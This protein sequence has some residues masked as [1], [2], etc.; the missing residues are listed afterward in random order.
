MISCSCAKGMPVCAKPP[1]ACR[2]STNAPT[3]YRVSW[4]GGGLEGAVLH[5]RDPAGGLVGVG[6]GPVYAGGRQTWRLHASGGWT[7]S[8]VM[9]S[10]VLARRAFEALLGHDNTTRAP[11]WRGD[12]RARTLQPRKPPRLQHGHGHGLVQLET[13]L[14][15][16][17]RRRRRGM[18]RSLRRRHRGH[19]GRGGIKAPRPIVV[20]V[21]PALE[22]RRRRCRDEAI[23][24]GRGREGK[25]LR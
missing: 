9:C 2:E 20:S 14:R 21:V 25:L 16:R 1:S 5:P 15:R 18:N 17:R 13:R 10:L 11:T 4:G 12:P 3:V 22:L 6:D 23:G 24:V 8:D 7:T 19:C